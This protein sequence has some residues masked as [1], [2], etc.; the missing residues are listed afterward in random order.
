MKKITIALLF[1]ISV[2]TIL[3]VPSAS[4]ASSSVNLTSKFIS[5][6]P[7]E[8]DIDV[9]RWNNKTLFTDTNGSSYTYGVGFDPY[10]DSYR[11]SSL[12]VSY[13]IADYKKTTFEATVSLQKGWNKG[14]NGQTTI[15]VYADGTRLYK[16]VFV[17]ST[18]AE[19][20]KLAVP[21]GTKNI[22]I[23]SAIQ[24][25][26]AGFQKV[27][28]GNPKL[29]DTLPQKAASDVISL[30]QDLSPTEVN[31]EYDF[32]DGGWEGKKPFQLTDGTNSSDAYGFKPYFPY[33]NKRLYARF[34]VGDYNYST[35]EATVSLDKSTAKGALGQSEFVIY[36]DNVKL[37]TK[38][39]KNNT[40]QQNIKIALPKGTKNLTFYTVINKGN[41]GSHAL[42]LDN[43]RLTKV[44]KA[45]PADSTISVVDLGT[46]SVSDDYDVYHNEWD[47]LAYQLSDGTLVPKGIGLEGSGSY[48]NK[49]SIWSKYYIADYAYPTLETKVSLDAR[50]KS[51]NRGTTNVFIWADGKVIYQTKMSNTTKTKNVILSIPKGTKYLKFGSKNTNGSKGHSVIFAD[52]RL[53]KRPQPPTVSGKIHNTTTVIKGKAKAKTTVQVKV[54]SKVIGKTTASSK[55]TYSVKIPKQKIGTQLN[56]I[57]IDSAKGT[58]LSTNVKVESKIIGRVWVAKHGKTVYKY[59]KKGKRVGKV[60]FGIKYNVYKKTS[61][62]Y[63]LKDG[64]YIKDTI[65]TRYK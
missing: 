38:T 11:L 49:S 8:H 3:Q 9:D 30:Y 51:G 65:S 40:P 53:T 12:Y 20:L 56:L 15:E 39:F 26:A 28:V 58:S 50:W 7:N 37:Y 47:N 24:D 18:P 5:D 32:A 16:K 21:A 45:I 31:N 29:T 60:K 10:Y 52:P 41:Q 61:T 44:L 35:L 63:Y 14:D 62:R 19:K 2:L 34:Y 23:Y 1:L 64:S 46:S 25:G 4:A 6:W 13:D 36:A 57:A 17:N 59:D 48:S 27:F 55:G 42:I 22:K 43:A 33:D 54:G